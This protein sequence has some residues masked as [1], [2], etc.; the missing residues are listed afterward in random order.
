MFDLLKD[1]QNLQL[2]LAQYCS[3]PEKAVLDSAGQE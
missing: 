3:K 2:S 1:T